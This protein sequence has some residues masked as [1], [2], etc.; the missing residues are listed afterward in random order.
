MRNNLILSKK[1]DDHIEAM[2]VLAGM[3]P[4]H[5]IDCVEVKEFKANKRMVTKFL[6]RNGLEIAKEEKF[7]KYIPDTIRVEEYLYKLRDKVTG[8]VL[9]YFLEEL[10]TRQESR[11]SGDDLV[12]GF[13]VEHNISEIFEGDPRKELLF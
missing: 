4:I 10:I 11:K 5:S 12:S 2:L 3:D 8:E 13:K 9:Y 1:I 6:N 7:N